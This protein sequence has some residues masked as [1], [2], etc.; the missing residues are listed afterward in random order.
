MQ[1]QNDALILANDEFFSLLKDMQET[2]T[3]AHGEQ[4]QA[5]SQQKDIALEEI[6][7]FMEK[8]QNDMNTSIGKQKDSLKNELHTITD[9]G[10]LKLTSETT[11]CIGQVKKA[12]HDGIIAI[13][14]V[15][16][17]FN[18]GVA[19]ATEEEIN[20]LKTAACKNATEL[21]EV[22]DTL[23]SK[24]ETIA[25][26]GCDRISEAIDVGKME[27]EKTT[28]ASLEKVI[29][30]RT[31]QEDAQYKGDCDGRSFHCSSR[32]NFFLNSYAQ[33]Y[34]LHTY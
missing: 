34:V 33:S 22:Q 19:L 26:R 12:T 13:E 25:S 29:Y 9:E 1:L 4:H 18:K 28:N 11:G 21:V 31:Q 6:K 14:V 23:K 8:L 16:S 5:I 30:S 3:T 2:I 20:K 32:N 27:I 17:N 15:A 10:I 24:L 7:T